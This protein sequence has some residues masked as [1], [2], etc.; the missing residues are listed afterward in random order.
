MLFVL[1]TI[2]DFRFVCFTDHAT[3]VQTK[4]KQQNAALLCRLSVGESDL[5]MLASSWRPS[6]VWGSAADDA[7]LPA[8]AQDLQAGTPD[9]EGGAGGSER[10]QGDFPG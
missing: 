9:A 5:S 8:S 10:I 7:A 4:Q 2:L 1:L 3:V 6:W